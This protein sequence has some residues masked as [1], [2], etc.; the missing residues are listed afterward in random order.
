MK[1]ND[2]KN[3][4]INWCKNHI[5]PLILFFISAVL[6]FIIVQHMK[7]DN[8]SL[9]YILTIIGFNFV[10]LQVNEMQIQRNIHRNEIR[11]SKAIDLS[12]KYQELLKNEIG[13]ALYVFNDC[14]EYRDALNFFKE[15][16]FILF[17]STEFDDL[18]KRNKNLANFRT[19]KQ[20]VVTINTKAS[21]FLRFN[22]ICVDDFLAI[23]YF[24]SRNWQIDD[25]KD[26]AALT[27]EEKE[28][29]KREIRSKKNEMIYFRNKIELFHSDNLNSALN[30]LE[31]MCM[32]LNSSL[33]EEDLLYK[34][35]HQTF[36]RTIIFFYPLI[37]RLNSG[38]QADKYYQHIVETYNRWVKIYWADLEKESNYK[39]A[40][41]K[42]LY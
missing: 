5:S 41:S 28:K 7:N 2:T 16:D 37:A 8:N 9:T 33:V 20:E 21:A 10:Y 27:A 29:K 42:K 22:N 36:I 4:I 35:L 15:F 14:S 19:S 18:C 13:Y 17:D 12:N 23:S 40:N 11:Y 6:I 3:K 39:T 31:A 1:K 26:T 25:F 32:S 24:N 30:K 38:K 34:S